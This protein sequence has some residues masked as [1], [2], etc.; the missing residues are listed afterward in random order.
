MMKNVIVISG[1]YENRIGK[2]DFSNTKK[3][4]NV[5][6]YPIEGIYPYR[7]CLRQEEVEKID[8]YTSSNIM[9]TFTK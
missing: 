6:F 8:S 4:G 3:T 5:M 7:V 1:K 2:A 9:L